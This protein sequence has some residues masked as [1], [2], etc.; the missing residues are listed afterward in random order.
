MKISK[1]IHLEI[2]EDKNK[3]LRKRGVVLTGVGLKRLQSAILEEE[4][5]KRGGKRFTQ[6]ELSDRIGISTS[7]LSRLWSLTS[8]I[9]PRTMRICF[10][11]FDL[12]LHEDDYTLYDVN[13]IYDKRE[14]FQEEQQA[15]F[16]GHPGLLNITLY[17]LRY[18]QLTL[19]EILQTASTELGIYR[20]Y[21]QNL[22]NK[23]QKNTQKRSP[24]SLKLSLLLEIA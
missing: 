16:G 10:S 12:V 6:V 3:S 24:T 2:K 4:R 1:K 14:Y 15:I 13:D 5:Q 21:L 18:Q 19:E 20:Q 17:H 7:S 8:R 23:L 9:D 22:L 11:A